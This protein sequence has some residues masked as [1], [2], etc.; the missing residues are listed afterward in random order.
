[1]TTAHPFAPLPW[2]PAARL[3]ARS[4]LA[5]L[6]ALECEVAGLPDWVL[7]TSEEETRAA[8]ATA[9]T[10][11]ASGVVAPRAVPGR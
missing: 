8:A 6:A 9:A 5:V 7:M 1:M 2:G 11:P 3:G 4:L 10:V